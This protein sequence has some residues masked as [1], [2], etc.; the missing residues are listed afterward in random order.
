MVYSIDLIILYIQVEI[1]IIISIS[2]RFGHVIMSNIR[3]HTNI[4]NDDVY[5]T[6]T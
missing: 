2:H 6:Y 1:D 4:T 3:G 5:L